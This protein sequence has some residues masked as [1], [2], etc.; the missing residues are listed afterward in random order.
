LVKLSEAIFQPARLAPSP[1]VMAP[2]KVPDTTSSP[3]AL[4]VPSFKISKIGTSPFF[5]VKILLPYFPRV[6]T[7]LPPVTLSPL[8]VN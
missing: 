8:H 1:A 5:T 6:A 2:I 4:I 7:T 3:V